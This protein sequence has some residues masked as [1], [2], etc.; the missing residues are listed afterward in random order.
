MNLEESI[1]KVKDSNVISQ[2]NKPLLI[3]CIFLN[4]IMKTIQEL[5]ILKVET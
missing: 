1:I 5:I 4:K 3:E 2:K